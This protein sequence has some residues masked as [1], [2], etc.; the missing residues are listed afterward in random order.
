MDARAPRASA[1][2]LGLL[3]WARRCGFVHGLVGLLHR[4]LRQGHAVRAATARSR[5]TAEFLEA[6]YPAPAP[7]PDTGAGALLQE[8][9]WLVGGALFLVAVAVCIEVAEVVRV[10][11][12]YRE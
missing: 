7:R 4:R 9:G 6:D 1:P 3:G 5:M 10:V 12:E 2:S 8:A 11:E